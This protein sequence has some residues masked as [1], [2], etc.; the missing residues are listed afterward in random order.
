MDTMAGTNERVPASRVPQDGGFW[1]VIPPM[2]T[3]LRNA[4]EL[5][6]PGLERLVSH[7]IGGG[8]HGLFILGTTGEGPVLSR[9]L[10]RE[11]IRQACRAVSGRVPVLVGITDTAFE[12]SVSLAETAAE[13]G[14]S[15]VV[16]APP[17]YFRLGQPEL[18]EY[19]AHLAARLPLP[20]MLYNIP[21]CTKTVFEPDTVRQAAGIP[22]VVGLKDS[23]GDMDYF[24]TVMTR[25]GAQPG[26]SLLIGDEKRLGE[27]VLTGA[28]GGVP[29][30]ANLCPDLYVAIFEA[31]CRRDHEALAR[32]QRRLLE[33]HSRLYEIGKHPSSF[34]KGLKCALSCLGIC[35]DAMA[36]PLHNFQQAERELVMMRLA[37]LQLLGGT[38]GS[39]EIPRRGPVATGE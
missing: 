26:F 9:H 22:G 6:L 36:E 35:E 1:G 16:V 39:M 20:M 31:A 33:L 24:R 8:V 25:L 21:S 34:L 7:I 11:L 17:P 14:A 27:A 15:A 29:G 4:N 12:E 3:P 19:V 10:Q 13:Q 32:L 38:T 30:G 37:E 23:S 18:L 5:D 2:V 28:R